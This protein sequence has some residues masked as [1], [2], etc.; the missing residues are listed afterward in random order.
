MAGEDLYDLVREGEYLARAGD[1]IACHTVPGRPP[2]SGGVVFKTPFGEL[3]SPNITPDLDTG[4]GSWTGRDFYRAL[5]LGVSPSG[6]FYYPVFPYEHYSLLTRYDVG[7]LYAYFRSLHAVTNPIESNRL[8]F[9][10]RIRGT[11]SVWRALYFRPQDF[12]PQSDQD[13]IWNRGYY[14]VEGLGHCQ[15]CHTPRNPLGARVNRLSYQGAKVENWFALNLTADRIRGIGDW[16][17]QDLVTYLKT[18]RLQ[19]RSVA[20]G[21][22]REVIENS[23][24][25]LKDDDLMAIATYL[26]SFST[27]DSSV[28]STREQ[29]LYLKNCAGC[30]HPLGIGRENVSVALANNSV[31]KSHNPNNLIN[32]I[33]LGVPAT[34]GL[35][36]MP[37]FEKKLSD[38]EI[39]HIANYVRRAWGNGASP[40]VSAR[41]VQNLRGV[42]TNDPARV[43]SS[44]R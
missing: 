42:G 44:S 29:S 27:D 12:T 26:K 24:S 21:P 20:L 9:P 7:A 38:D 22:M 23:L 13:E 33:L 25:H 11:L 39:A 5:K 34:A 2:F 6:E 14:L 3:V 40:A 31:V 41:D 36:P 8:D 35:P 15:A 18:G 4:I 32:A 30:H 19:E 10:F 28:V 1:C 37:A 17:A 43:Q 16:S